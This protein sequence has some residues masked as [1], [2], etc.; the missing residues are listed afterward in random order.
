MCMLSYFPSGVQPVERHLENGA[1]SNPDGHGWAI[2]TDW[3]LLQNKSLNSRD[4]IEEF[5]SERKAHPNGPA[6]FHSRIGTGGGITQGNCH[7]FQVGKDNQTVLAHNGILFASPKGETRSDTRI[8]AED[9]FPVRFRRLDRPGVRYQLRQ[10]M[11]SA[12]NWYPNKILVLT[13]NP[14]YEFGAYLFGEDLG[15]WVTPDGKKEENK[16]PGVTAW[17]SNSG[18]EDSWKNYYPGSG[19]WKSGGYRSWKYKNG[20]LVSEDVVTPTSY[21]LGYDP[22]HANCPH[23]QCEHTVDPDT[24]ICSN[25][26]CCIDCGDQSWDC[27]C[28][29]PAGQVKLYSTASDE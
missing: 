4:M 17:H 29:I 7:P 6:L 10:Y 8:F 9:I 5:I 22:E 13:A 21:G 15:H 16:V 25:C 12:K 2:V 1:I 26:Q 24:D 19:G 20:V 23:C 18:Y 3:G 28:Y 14:R 27:M 11:Y